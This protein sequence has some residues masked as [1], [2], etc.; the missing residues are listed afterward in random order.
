AN[1]PKPELAVVRDLFADV[2]VSFVAPVLAVGKPAELRVVN[3]RSYAL[4]NLRLR[5]SGGLGPADLVLGA[6]PA[7]GQVTASAPWGDGSSQARF[8][9]SFT[10]HAGLDGEAHGEVMLPVAQNRPLIVNDDYLTT[11]ALDVVV[12][13]G[14]KALL[15]AGRRVIASGPRQKL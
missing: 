10:S 8:D 3:R 4:D 12:P 15:Y 2:G 1:K 11:H 9:A 14:A 6:L 13:P 5:V 7:H